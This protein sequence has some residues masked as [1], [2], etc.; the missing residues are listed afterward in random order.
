MAVRERLAPPATGTPT[1]KNVRL[2]SPPPVMAGGQTVTAMALPGPLATTL[3]IV[4][5][6]GRL[7]VE[8]QA[9]SILRM[10][11]DRQQAQR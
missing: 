6:A 8:G 11:A 2:T 5:G 7:R 9:N 3:V 10:V 1:R 4:G